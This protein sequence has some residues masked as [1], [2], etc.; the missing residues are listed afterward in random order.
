MRLKN[1]GCKATIEEKEKLYSILID[2]LSSIYKIDC[3]QF[4][5]DSYVELIERLKAD[6]EKLQYLQSGEQFSV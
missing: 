6:L 4:N 1:S 2:K 3:Y 5:D